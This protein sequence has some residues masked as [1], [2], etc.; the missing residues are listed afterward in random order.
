[1]KWTK[2]SL[3]QITNT[4]LVSEIDLSF[5]DIVKKL[6]PASAKSFDSKV[7]ARW[8]LKF[9][10]G[11]I[12]TIYDWKTAGDIKKVG[13]WNIGGKSKKVVPYIYQ[14]FDKERE[15]IILTFKSDYLWYKE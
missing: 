3:E 14:I 11:N 10:D 4:F 5:I 15:L 13:T 1:M 8:V 9:E 6:G 12:A 2:G 7:R